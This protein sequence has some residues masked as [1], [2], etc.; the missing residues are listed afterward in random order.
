MPPKKRGRPGETGAQ[1]EAQPSGA[2][3]VAP[4]RR[5]TRVQRWHGSTQH[6]ITRGV[7]GVLKELGARLEKE[8]AALVKEARRQHKGSKPFDAAA[9]V[10]ALVRRVEQLAQRELRE[11]AAAKKAAKVPRPTAAAA[12]AG[13]TFAAVDLVLDELLRA[14]TAELQPETRLT[15]IPAHTDKEWLLAL[16]CRDHVVWASDPYI[17][18]VI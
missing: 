15:V 18:Y 9:E 7:A 3:T 4:R 11:E 13:D 5:H 6:E 14:W 12:V 8:Q 1:Q 17:L 10:E 16:S 2:A